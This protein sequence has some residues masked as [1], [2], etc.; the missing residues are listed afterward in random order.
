[1]KLEETLKNAVRRVEKTLRTY[2]NYPTTLGYHTEDL[3][4]RE[5]HEERY[6]ERQRISKERHKISNA[7]WVANVGEAL[8]YATVAYEVTRSPLA[9]AV[10][11][12][13]VYFG[14]KLQYN[15]GKIKRGVELDNTTQ[16]AL[17]AKNARL[18]DPE[19]N[20]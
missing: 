9:L 19:A 16:A 12:I 7:N 20:A 13:V 5:D 15:S 2:F 6:E 17:K 10:T 3:H 11:P 8:G 1:M 18:N 4:F 14:R